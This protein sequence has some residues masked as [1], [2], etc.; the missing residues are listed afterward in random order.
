LGELAVSGTVTARTTSRYQGSSPARMLA[1]RA[2][3]TVGRSAAGLDVY[4][5]FN[6]DHRGFA[7]A[8]MERLREEFRTRR[9]M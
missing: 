3:R 8:N 6:N 9:Q 7:V 2:R 5:F 4:A 1:A